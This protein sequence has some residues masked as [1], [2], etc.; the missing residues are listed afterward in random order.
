MRCVMVVYDV[1]VEC[2]VLLLACGCTLLE[3]EV[4]L[5]CRVCLVSLYVQ[6]YSLCVSCYR[7]PL[8][9]YCSTNGWP[10]ACM[11]LSRCELFYTVIVSSCI[12]MACVWYGNCNGSC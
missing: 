9:R 4:S 11:A 8:L 3:F 2:A 5:F 1:G 6:V 7:W 12:G 10:A